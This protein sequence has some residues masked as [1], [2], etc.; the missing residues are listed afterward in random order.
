MCCVL[1]SISFKKLFIKRK[2]TTWENLL[3]L[4][5]VGCGRCWQLLEMAVLEGYAQ[6]ISSEDMA[7]KTFVVLKYD[8]RQEKIN[9]L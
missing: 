2:Y 1:F 9:E 8:V 6:M 5:R 4:E 3:S 7:N